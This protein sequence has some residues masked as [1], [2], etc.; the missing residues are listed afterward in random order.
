[1]ELVVTMPVL[2]SMSV[3]TTVVRA[4]VTA[5][6]ASYLSH[7]SVIR[8]ELGADSALHVGEVLA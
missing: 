3:Y 6:V 5:P 2:V 1:M 7:N 8:Y 4:C